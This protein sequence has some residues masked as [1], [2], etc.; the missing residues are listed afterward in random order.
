VP[1]VVH[2]LSSTLPL[3]RSVLHTAFQ[4]SQSASC[5]P[6]A[7]SYT[8]LDTIC[9]SHCLP[10]Q[11]EC[12]MSS[13]H[14]LL[15]FPR[16]NL[17]STLPSNTARVPR[18]VHPL[19]PTLPSIRSVLHTAFQHSQSASCRP[20]AVSYTSLDTI[21]SPHCLPTQSEYLMSS[22]TANAKP[23]H[24]LHSFH[25]N[26]IYFQMVLSLAA[27]CFTLRFLF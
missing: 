20:S 2:P 12:L 9:S 1:H 23:C 24:C 13:I 14:C 16:Y 22:N 3:I 8:S 17:F 27:F 25:I 11:P 21:C 6:S 4:H 7:V 5:R 19:S 15:H 18:V 10:T 26:L